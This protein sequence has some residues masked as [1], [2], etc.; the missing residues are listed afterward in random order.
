VKIQPGDVIWC[1]PGD[2]H[3]H[4]AS[5]AE[6]MSHIA[7]TEGLDGKLVDWL[8]KVRDEQYRVGATRKP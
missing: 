4:G 8:E 5:P 7:I 1:P 6:R 3:W 2:K